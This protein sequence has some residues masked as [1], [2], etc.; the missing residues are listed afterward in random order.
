MRSSKSS[1]VRKITRLP[2]QKPFDTDFVTF[3]RTVKHANLPPFEATCRFVAD[4]VG[5][6]ES[7][8]IIG[9]AIPVEKGRL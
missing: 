5:Y 3:N 2:K 6:R 9:D 7:E 8:N 4:I 1:Q